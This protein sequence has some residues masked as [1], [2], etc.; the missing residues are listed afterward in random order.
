MPAEG[1]Q[2]SL[3]AAA[4][5][6]A[7]G[8]PAA[9]FRDGASA[10]LGLPRATGFHQHLHPALPEPWSPP[11]DAASDAGCQGPGRTADVPVAQLAGIPPAGVELT[12]SKTA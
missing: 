6:D 10:G 3:R 1:R 7:G 11:P 5:T 9:A 8:A 2:L 4:E 12:R